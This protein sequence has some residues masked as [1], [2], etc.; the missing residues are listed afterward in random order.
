MGIS[1]PRMVEAPCLPPVRIVGDVP[2]PL[3][4]VLVA[5]ATDG[6]LF[7]GAPKISYAMPLGMNP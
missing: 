2:W 3:P 7:A 1:P 6:D 5:M 4:P